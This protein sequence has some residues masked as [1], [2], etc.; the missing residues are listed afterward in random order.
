MYGGSE[1]DDL[2]DTRRVQS[3]QEM[4]LK[5]LIK[6]EV[7]V[8]IVSKACRPDRGSRLRDPIRGLFEI[9]MSEVQ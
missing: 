3:K 7:R 2:I 9:R 4:P 1:N 6:D 5:G 8:V